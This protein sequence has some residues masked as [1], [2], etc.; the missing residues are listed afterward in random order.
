MEENK[1][2]EKIE[3][4]LLN[5]I[6]NSVFK[7][8][9]EEFIDKEALLT[10]EDLIY[11]LSGQ[12]SGRAT[13]Y[14]T[15]IE[16]LISNLENLKSEP[17]KE[18]N[19]RLAS[20]NLF[21]EGVEKYLYDKV[22]IY[23]NENEDE[24]WLWPSPDAADLSYVIPDYHDDFGVILHIDAK[25][26][27]GLKNLG[28]SLTNGKIGKFE[29]NWNQLS[30]YPPLLRK[31][32]KDKSAYYRKKHSPVEAKRNIDGSTYYTISLFFQHITFINA[33]KLDIDTFKS[34]EISGSTFDNIAYLTCVPNGKL[35]TDYYDE[36]FQRGKS[37]YD[38]GNA[39][40]GIPKDCRFA[41][42]NDGS[43]CSFENIDEGPR[44]KFVYTPHGVRNN[45]TEKM[46]AIIADR[47][48]L[49]TKEFT[50]QFPY[51]DSTQF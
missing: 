46:K 28:D 19:M 36:F 14:K 9:K 32:I 20:L 3:L 49:K 50:I 29:I 31:R 22:S 21:S 7:D 24:Y 15:D 1:T 38:H 25:S 39:Q 6:Y 16:T 41:C 8:Y 42:Y 37:G 44:F 4:S 34:M 5:E 23:L 18:L 2:I 27:A 48:N 33:D 43:E 51:F 10:N 12:G 35:E 11:Y 17:K 26:V 13:C 45:P 47:N 40:T 30:Y